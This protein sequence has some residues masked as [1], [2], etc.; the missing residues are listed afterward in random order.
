MSSKQIVLAYSSD[1]PMSGGELAVRK[2]FATDHVARLF[3]TDVVVEESADGLTGLLA[4]NV[5]SEPCGWPSF[6]SSPAGASAAWLHVPA[7]AGGPDRGT[8]PLQ[9]A[10]DVT[11]G[12]IEAPT[13]G[14]PF[15][16]ITRDTS[17]AL[18]LANDVFGMARI[19]RFSFG[20]LEVWSSR[21][22][23][24]HVFAGVEP[25]VNRL[26][27]ESMATLGWSARGITHMGDGQQ[28]GPGSLTV[29][30]PGARVVVSSDVDRWLDDMNH[31][32]PADLRESAGDMQLSLETAK[33]W[34]RKPI[35]DLSGGKDSRVIAAAAVRARAA[36]AVR[37]VRTDHGEVEIAE[38]LMG[39][40][41]SPVE[42][43]V[44]D[45]ASPKVAT[46]GIEERL[47]S[48]HRI[49]E[50]YYLPRSAYKAPMFHG[51]KRAPSARLNG[52]G[53][54][55]IQ[56]GSIM[57][58]AWRQKILDG[59]F[60]AA[61]QRLISMVR[62]PLGPREESRQ[63]VA[64]ILLN[65]ARD[66]QRFGWNSGIA[67]VDYVYNFDKMP[68]WSNSFGSGETI[69]PYYAPA[70][71][72]HVAQSFTNSQ[73]YGEMHRELLRGLIPEWADVPFY[74]PSQRTRATAFMWDH[75][76]WPQARFLLDEEM[77]LAP[78]YDPD[79]VR[80]ILREVDAGDGG[81]HHET[82]L[83]RALWEI[84]FHGHVEEVATEAR[85][86]ADLIGLSDIQ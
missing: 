58:G 77:D 66:S 57:P 35:A 43:R 1:R 69:L 55:A 12:R 36:E 28:L 3:G 20:G 54:E 7:I 67:A 19:F 21:Q 79:S 83:V 13:V 34:A 53:G 85:A 59:G 71:L 2:R 25:T 74:K 38:H 31:A 9:L 72:T 27:W 29:A 41:G 32:P 70:M 49:W 8:D 23:L 82:A 52:L 48:Q 80:A 46:G 45:V 51:I 6:I 17:G 33:Y 30:D 63:H 40:I 61:E 5:A 64:D 47:L 18:R 86:V 65:L 15:G 75:D 37:T 16:V 68:Y 81:G 44:Q 56:G 10:F 39:L 11:E 4:W 76:D 60:P 26:A 62:G 50:G 84:S 14:A 42:H 73:P 78:S 22:G 24:A